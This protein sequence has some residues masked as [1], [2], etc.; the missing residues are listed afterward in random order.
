MLLCET[1]SPARTPKLSKRVI[2]EVCPRGILCQG[3][4]RREFSQHE[5][6]KLKVTLRLEVP[7]HTESAFGFRMKTGGSVVIRATAHRPSSSK[8]RFNS[9]CGLSGVASCPRGSP[10]SVGND[11]LRVLEDGGEGNK[12]SKFLGFH[13]HY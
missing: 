9:A 2:G 6:L 1:P 13:H 5:F 4:Y 12:Q 8:L 7:F 11:V 10:T 3:V